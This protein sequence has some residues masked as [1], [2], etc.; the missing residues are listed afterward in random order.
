M[1]RMFLISAIILLNV[2]TA[3]IISSKDSS[4]IWSGIKNGIHIPVNYFYIYVKDSNGNPLQGGLSSR[5]NTSMLVIVLV[6]FPPAFLSSDSSR[7]PTSL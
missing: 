5:L 3:D 4:V 7:L 2:C 6:V 1:L